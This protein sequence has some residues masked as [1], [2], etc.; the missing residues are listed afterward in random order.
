M[1][2]AGFGFGWKMLVVGWGV[3]RDGRLD[4]VGEVGVIVGMMMMM[5]VMGG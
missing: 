1:I 2:I 4:G 3:G 5:I